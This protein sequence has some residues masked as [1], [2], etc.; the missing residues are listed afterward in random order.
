MK[1]KRNRAVYAILIILVII[2][3]LMS[4]HY[5]AYLPKWINSYAGDTLWALMIFIIIGFLFK[6]LNSI[7]TGIYALAFAFAIEI[8]QLYHATWIDAI[9]K[10]IL[11]GLVLGFGFLW[12]DLVCYVVGIFIGV[13]IETIFFRMSN[14]EQIC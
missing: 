3:G 4:R 2:L 10:T 9:R 8:S 11:G 6:R 12:S 14:M 7:H 5:S 13:L 1:I